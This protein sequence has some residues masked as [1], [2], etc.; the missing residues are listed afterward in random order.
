MDN[1][2]P[3]AEQLCFISIVFPVSDDDQIMA[4]KKKVFEAVKELPKVK[5]ELRITEMRNGVSD[6]RMGH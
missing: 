3:V 6:G 2:S 4:V 1:N 5:T